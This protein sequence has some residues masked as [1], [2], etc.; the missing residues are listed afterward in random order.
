MALYRQN[1]SIALPA[2]QTLKGAPRIETEFNETVGQRGDLTLADLSQVLSISKAGISE[3]SSIHVE[4]LSDQI[5]LKF[6]MRVDCK[7][8]EDTPLTPYK[9]S[10]LQSAFTVLEERV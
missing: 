4:F 5:A 3:Q 6:T 1:G 2:P 10:N 8:W 7:P 9:G